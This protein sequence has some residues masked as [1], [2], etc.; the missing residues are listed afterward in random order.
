MTP[1]P[2]EQALDEF[3]SRPKPAET[4]EE[5]RAQR[6]ERAKRYFVKMTSGTLVKYKRE[7]W[8]KATHETT[9]KTCIVLGQYYV[10]GYLLC[11]MPYEK[12][13]KI[14]IRKRIVA[15]ALVKKISP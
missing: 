7:D 13:G 12:D 2:F 3:F 1:D 8:Y 9:G 14:V 15:P 11:A 5:K 10:S 4:P 6:R